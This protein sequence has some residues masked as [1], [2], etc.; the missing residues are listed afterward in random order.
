MVETNIFDIN[1][2]KFA[3]LFRILPMNTYNIMN[4]IFGLTSLDLCALLISDL[5]MLINVILYCIIAAY[6]TIDKVYQILFI[7]MIIE[8]V[9][10]IAFILTWILWIYWNISNEYDKVKQD[11]IMSRPTEIFRNQNKAQSLY[12]TS[13]IFEQDLDENVSNF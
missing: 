11:M 9:L 7:L 6:F 2:W 5:A 1:G 13:T 10:C 12:E 4:Y 8:L 3:F